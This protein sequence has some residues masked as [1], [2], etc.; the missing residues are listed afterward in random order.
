M[1]MTIETIEAMSHYVAMKQALEALEVASS[2]VD[3]YY[4]PKG[5]TMLPEVENAITA[6]RRALEQQPAEEPVAFPRQAGDSTWII[7]TAFIWRVKHTIEPDTPYEWTPSEEQ[8]ETVLL[9]LEKIPLPLYTRPQPA[10]Q[11]VGLTDEEILE[12]LCI[13]DDDPDDWKYEIQEVR[14]IEAKLKEKNGSKA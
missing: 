10:A 2:C 4:L 3:G 1:N 5:K 12:L 6:L 13:H 11:W 8:I 14:A 7:D 9:A